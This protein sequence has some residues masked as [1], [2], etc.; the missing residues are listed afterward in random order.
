MG[1]LIRWVFALFL[2]AA[3]F[4]P[5]AWN[6]T[7]WSV[8]NWREQTSLTVFLGLLL[9]VGWII[10]LRATLRSI[11]PFGM[12]LVAALLGALGWV[13]Y[14]QG[15]LSLSNRDL[16]TW[17]AILALSLVLGVGLS[18]SFARKALSGQADMDDVDDD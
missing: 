16:N 4:N 1:F 3:T 14:D 5:T 2:V 6:Y 18:W 12:I 17:L 13:L 7:S 8:G 9:L 10:Y 15:W 11:G